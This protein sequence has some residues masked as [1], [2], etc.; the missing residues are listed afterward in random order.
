MQQRVIQAL[1]GL[2]Y[3]VSNTDISVISTAISCAE[4]KIKAQCNLESI[5]AQLNNAL[6]DMAVSEFLFI[7]KSVYPDDLKMFD[8]D[9][10]VK[11]IKEGDTSISYDVG[12]ASSS[13]EQRLDALISFFANKNSDVIVA[14]RRLKW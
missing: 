2:G 12:G 6:C 10:A 14:N 4:D 9:T 5:P 8:L 13:D 7:K 11:Q 1:S 3:T